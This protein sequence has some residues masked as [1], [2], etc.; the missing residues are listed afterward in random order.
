MIWTSDSAC[1]GT[2]RSSLPFPPTR[3]AMGWI[4]YWIPLSFFA[5]PWEGHVTRTRVNSCISHISLSGLDTMSFFVAVRRSDPEFTIPK[6]LATLER[7]QD[8]LSQIACFVSLIYNK[9]SV[10]G[11]VNEFRYHLS[12]R[13]HRLLFLT[14]KKR[15]P[16]GTHLEG[17]SRTRS[18]RLQILWVGDNYQMHPISAL[19]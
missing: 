1:K 15:D 3:K 12:S 2:H 9:T 13:L 16:T 4:G 10:H 8:D 6:V 17:S 11:K 14:H 18:Q 5:H 19:G 7:L